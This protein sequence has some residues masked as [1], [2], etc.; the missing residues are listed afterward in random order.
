[1][2]A[3]IYLSFNRSLAVKHGIPAALV[4][5]EISRWCHENYLDK[6]MM[7]NGEA[8]MFTNHGRIEKHMPFFSN[9]TIRRAI[10]T[11]KE[12][13]LIKQEARGI[14]GQPNSMRYI[15]LPYHEQ[16]SGQNEQMGYGQN[17]QM[18]GQ[19]EQSEHNNSK[20]Y[21]EESEQEKEK[22]SKDKKEKA[23][24]ASQKEKT[25]DLP[26]PSNPQYKRHYELAKSAIEKTGQTLNMH[27][28]K[29]LMKVIDDC[30]EEWSLDD[31]E[32][33]LPMFIDYKFEQ[34]D[35]IIS[36]HGILK[37]NPRAD[38][39]YGNHPYGQ[40]STQQNTG[41]QSDDSLLRKS[42]ED[43]IQLAEQQY[44]AI[45]YESRKLAQ[46]ESN[47]NGLKMMKER[48]NSIG[49]GTPAIYTKKGR[50]ALSEIEKMEETDEDYEK[51]DRQK[52]LIKQQFAQLEAK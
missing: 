41:G 46:Y 32:R 6:K 4:H 38:R 14:E 26:D 52:Q 25:E 28:I 48:L 47:A 33:L 2:M 13:N 1:M 8:W 37:F 15:A 29:L 50:L 35:P 10:Q 16:T 40:M 42:R 51:A 23:H 24:F 21:K 30:T 36:L 19:N 17:E 39:S 5:Q 12:A 49:R 20:Q 7:I 11:L 27:S 44:Q 34:G 43:N 3:D 31:Q 22:S 9:S 45:D 18:S